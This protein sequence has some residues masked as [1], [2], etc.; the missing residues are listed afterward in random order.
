MLISDKLEKK[1]KSVVLKVDVEENNDQL[2]GDTDENLIELVAL[3][4]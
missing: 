2:E 3:L 4:A 1:D